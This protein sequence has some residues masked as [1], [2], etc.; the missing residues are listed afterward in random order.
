MSRSSTF[1]NRQRPFVFLVAS[2]GL[3]IF[4][5]LTLAAF[6]FVF[7]FNA[8]GF[9]GR[10][11]C[12]TNECVKEF[13]GS[14]DQ[15]FSVVKSTLDFAV[16]IATIGG[17]FVALQ[18]YFNTSENAA[19]AN[20]IEHLKVFGEYL[21]NEVKKR[22]RLSNES[23]DT[24][25]LY[26]KIFPDSRKGRA[27]VSGEFRAFICKLNELIEE[28]N[29]RCVIGTPGGFSYKDHQRRL[30]EHLAECGIVVYLA[31]RK[32]YFEMEIQLLSLLQ[33]V[34][35]SFCPADSLPELVKPAY[36]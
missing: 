4:L 35:Q 3:V 5:G 17:I 28:T 24:L 33:R 8:E 32:D 26:S 14:T 22:D 10:A 6:I 2:I 31:P 27:I 7:S 16:A 19:L 36:Y 25:L 30:S 21:E 1:F 13:L 20:H 11:V 23:F 15:A 29:E 9:Y 34:C 18:S 12:L